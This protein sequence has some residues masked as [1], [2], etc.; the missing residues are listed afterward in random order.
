VPQPAPTSDSISDEMTVGNAV[1]SADIQRL[2]GRPLPWS[3]IPI[4]ATF[5]ASSVRRATPMSELQNSMA[6]PAWSAAATGSS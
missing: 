2:E 1:T 5:A 3:R 6:R 4:P